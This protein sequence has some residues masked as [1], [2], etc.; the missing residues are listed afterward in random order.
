M[1]IWAEL[2]KLI[3]GGR[4]TLKNN[5]SICIDEYYSF[6]A[7]EG[8]T[9]TDT[10]ARLNTLI[11]KCKRYGIPRTTEENNSLFL[12]SFGDEWSTIRMSMKAILDLETW[13]LADLFGSLMSQESQVMQMKRNLGGPL[14]LV[15]EDGCS[16]KGKEGKEVKK[17]KK[18]K[19]MVLIA[20]SDQSSEEE[21][22]SMKE[23]MKTLALITREYRKGGDRKE[24]RS[25]SR[26]S[27]IEGEKSEK[28]ERNQ[29]PYQRA[30]EQ[31]KE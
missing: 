14:A 24:Y 8:E 17:E 1:D 26:R 29:K 27:F 22:I 9:L 3:E 20:D 18:K 19:K 5:R 11:S 21:E 31:R 13:T 4:K 23:I 15:A 2:E 28:K 30:E 25:F 7:K 12:K 6:K 16:G 10:Y